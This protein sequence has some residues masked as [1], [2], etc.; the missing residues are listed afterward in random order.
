VKGT[1]PARNFLLLV[2]A[3]AGCSE[4]SQPDALAP[5]SEESFD[6]LG[7]A[8]DESLGCLLTDE[9]PEPVACQ[10]DRNESESYTHS[11]V[12]HSASGERYWVT[13]SSRQRVL[14][15]GWEACSERIAAPPPP[16]FARECAGPN[17][18]GQRGYPDSLCSEADTRRL[19]D[20]G[21]AQSAWD[22]N[23]CR[24]P[25][26]ESEMDCAGVGQV[27]R[28]LYGSW[29]YRHAWPHVAGFA[30]YSQ[31][32]CDSGGLPS[33]GTGGFMCITRD[34]CTP[35]VVP[36]L[37]CEEVFAG[38]ACSE[39]IA[40]S[41]CDRVEACTADNGCSGLLECHLGPC[42]GGDYRNEQDRWCF[43]QSCPGCL[44][45]SAG[46]ELFDAL[47]ACAA[48]ACTVECEY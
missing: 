8:V 23:C 42:A 33:G 31:T 21:G 24:R 9:P 3:L 40:R 15:D 2:G 26:C 19:F 14:A 36:N 6:L 5:C 10:G 16:C 38:N 22:E 47:D 25:L 32:G 30:N 43:D 44:E 7:V 18:F 1:L 48:I 39:C 46:R 29:G 41:C 28:A 11:C 27:C 12:Q 45:P 35:T 4:S 13:I 37:G 17:E 34:A 20:C